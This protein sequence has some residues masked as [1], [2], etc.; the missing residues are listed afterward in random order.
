M[1]ALFLASAVLLAAC[2]QAPLPPGEPPAQPGAAFAYPMRLIGTEPFWGATITADTITLSGAD[3]PHLRFAAGE[4]AVTGAGVRWR[5]NSASGD[6]VE[7]TLVRETCSDGMSDR[8]YPFQAT[9]VL[10]SETLRGCAITESEF[11]RPPRP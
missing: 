3:R 6:P 4:R 8:T 11:L 9:V 5:T 1:R 2:S 10:G 7:V